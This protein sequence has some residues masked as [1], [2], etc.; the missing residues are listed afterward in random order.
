MTRGFH[1]QRNHAK[2]IKGMSIACVALS[3]AVILLCL[4]GMAV[5]S[6]LGP[7]LLESMTDSYYDYDYYDFY[8]SYQ[9]TGL[10]GMLAAASGGFGDFSQASYYGDFYDD[11]YSYQLAVTI[12]N[13]MLGFMIL[14]E[15]VVL[16][17]GIMV[18]RNYDKPEKLGLVFGWSIGG[19]VVGFLCTGIIQAVLFIIIAVFAN[20]DKK[21]YKAGMYYA[22]AAPA[23][24]AAAQ[25]AG[26][27]VAP[28]PVQPA[29]TMQ[30]AQPAAMQ[31]VAQPVAQQPMATQPVAQPVAQQPMAT[32]P[33]APAEARP[34]PAASCAPAADVVQE[35]VV[36]AEPVPAE[37]AV[38]DSAAEPASAGDADA[39]VVPVIEDGA[40]V[41]IEEAA[42]RPS[43]N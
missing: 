32:Q 26:Q 27:P 25:A 9:Q 30:A 13:I 35:A 31:P 21:L 3:G 7:L 2:A 6:A 16:V 4:I 43:G 18:L 42:D 8:S 29:Q 24:Y 14:G 19:A 39:E 15:A 36:V 28:M 17:A 37:P 5:M 10:E 22:G 33:V 41:S 12:L 23:A 38:V 1:M 20:S 34:L 40:V 11:Y